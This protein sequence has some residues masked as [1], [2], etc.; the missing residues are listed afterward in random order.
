MAINL[1]GV[2]L[3]DEA[4]SMHYYIE[5]IAYLAADGAES[6]EER[7]LQLRSAIDGITTADEYPSELIVPKSG[8]VSL[9][10]KTR[11]VARFNFRPRTRKSS[12]E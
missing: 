7:Y 10:S 9:M 12:N 11:K 1:D 8:L 3:L 5:Y 2:N 4:T 6:V